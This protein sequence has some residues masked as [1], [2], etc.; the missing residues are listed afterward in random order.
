MSTTK[1]L[2]EKSLGTQGF[3]GSIQGYGCMSLTAFGAPEKAEGAEQTLKHVLEQGVTLLNTATFYGQNLNEEIIGSVIKEF[4][5][6]RVKITTKWGPTWRDGQLKHDG[7]REH[8]RAEC[9][10]SLKRLGVDY[11]DMFIFRGPPDANTPWEDTIQ[12]MK[13]LVE[14]G[15]VKYLGLSEVSPAD[16]R[17]AHAIH[18]ITALEME[19]SLFSRD[20]EEDLVPTARELGI[21]FLAYSP[22][23]RG[24]LTGALK[25]KEDVPEQARGFNPRMAGEH[26]D[27]NAKLVQNVVQL[28]AKKGVTPGQL[29]LAWVTQQ[30]DDV[31]PIPGTKRV[32]CVDEN[33]AAVNV[34]LTAE[35]MKELEDAVP[36]HEVAGDRYHDMKHIS[37]KYDT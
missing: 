28:A 26:F 8:C 32:A 2:P 5:R 4:P 12:F 23:G 35:E 19:W 27:K 17:R 15:H 16:I 1:T 21:G 20:A 7:S 34:K 14:E 3:S 30:G 31:I 33:V 37:Y 6:E 22:L 29:A 25:S 10:S 11:L 18:P 24:L 36:Q 9:F 13:E